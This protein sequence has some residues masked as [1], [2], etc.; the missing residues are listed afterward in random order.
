MR[1]KNVTWKHGVAVGIAAVMVASTASALVVV[2]GKTPSASA[3]EAR[4]RCVRALRSE[5]SWRAKYVE[6][7]NGSDGKRSVVR[8]EV[9]VRQP[10]DY[11]VVVRERDDRGREVV[12]TSIRSGDTLYTRRI[13]D[14]G[15]PVLHVM[16]GV[17]P[18][19]GVEMD[20]ALGETVRSVAD[21]TSLR[22]A[23]SER[24]R[25][26][27]AYKL[28]LAP[29]RFVWT[30]AQ[31]G[32]PVREREVSGATVVREVSFDS[33]EADPVVTDA[34][35]SVAS[36][37]SVESTVVEDL[38]FRPVDAP[39][40]AWGLLGFKPVSLGVPTGYQ[41]L[42]QGYCDPSVSPGDREPE[43]AFVTLLS[44]GTNSL[45]VTQTLRPGLGDAMYPV[46]ADEPDAPQEVDL[47]GHRAVVYSDAAGGQ[48]TLARRDI[49]IC[50][51][52]N[53]PDEALIAFGNTIR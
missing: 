28:E 18:S 48:L 3:D 33:F 13:E 36:L 8:T 21:A 31:S 51:E 10:G 24:I 38:G 5:R 44:D 7:E 2:L 34:D 53:V 49:L 35:F 16:K 14:D 4:M 9:T 15:T 52:G 46:P 29:N 25:G 22:V 40:Q 47:G 19:L 32:L 41:V 23:G 6:T 20:N 30:D 1:M 42:E 39:A 43:A 37:G 12:S 26:K 17:R 45:L 50:V 27:A 11:R